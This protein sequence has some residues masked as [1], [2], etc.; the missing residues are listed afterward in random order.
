VTSIFERFSAPRRETTRPAAAPAREAPAGGASGLRFIDP[1]VLARIGSL[2]LVARTV[3]EG[4]LSGLHRSAH[5]GVS[6]DFAEH[7]PYMPGDDIRR[8][9]WRLWARTDRYYVKE[10]EADTNANVVL[11]LDVSSSMRFASDPGR[12]SKLDYARILIACLAQFSRQQRDRVG[13]VTFDDDVREVVPPSAKHLPMVL[14]ALERASAGRPGD[15]AAPLRRIADNLRR[16]SVVILVSDFYEEPARV[17]D[18]VAALR[19]KGN[20]L[21]AF[22][23]LDPAEID[24]PFD[25][26]ATFQDLESGEHLPVIPSEQRDRYR[27]LIADHVAELRRRLGDQRVEYAM[28]DTRVPIDYALFEYLASRQRMARVR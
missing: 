19:G 22:H 12:L 1:A 3:V 27:D 18:A 13:L 15:L 17:I 2:E 4:F 24:F 21:I 5:L 20:D 25:E 23:I 9:D 16:R 14:H 10:F 11:L 7:R 8:I 6:M 26:A 28:F